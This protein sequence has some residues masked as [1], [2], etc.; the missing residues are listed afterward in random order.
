MLAPIFFLILMA[1]FETSMI[2]L[3]ESGMRVGLS[4]LAR[5]VR[6]GRGQCLTDEEARD[7]VCG[8]AFARDC[9]DDLVIERQRFPT[10]LGA[11]SAAAAGFSDLG[12]EEIVQL[13]A[14]YPWRV[15]TPIMAPLYG[16]ENGELELS[17]SIVFMNEGFAGANC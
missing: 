6:T 8:K 3:A 2:S 14:T 11:E 12:A 7:L 13:R 17:H 5:V 15:V 9:G 16:D 10:G 1:I 4:D